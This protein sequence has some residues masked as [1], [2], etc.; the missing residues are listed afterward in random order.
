VKTAAR[1][2]FETAIALPQSYESFEV[3]ALDANGRV[4]GTSR[5]FSGSAQ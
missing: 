2:G 4:L 3:Q 5:T 1:T